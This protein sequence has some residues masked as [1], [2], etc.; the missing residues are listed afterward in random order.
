MS[1]PGW[2]ASISCLVWLLA[3]GGPLGPVERAAI[4]VREVIG[5]ERDDAPVGGHHMDMALA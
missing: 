1:G 2:P 4:A 3:A 5:A